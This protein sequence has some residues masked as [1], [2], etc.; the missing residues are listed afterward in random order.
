MRAI[1]L[2][3]FCGKLVDFQN[4]SWAIRM[5]TIRIYN[6]ITINWQYNNVTNSILYDFSSSSKF[7]FF[8]TFSDPL[9]LETATG[10]RFDFLNANPYL[11]EESWSKIFTGNGVIHE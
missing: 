7:F 3:N 6:K 8:D 11:L 9:N 2:N 1:D 4:A 10:M 5:A